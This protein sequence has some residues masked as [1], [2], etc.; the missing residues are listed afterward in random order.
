M[1]TAAKWASSEGG[2]QEGRKEH[3][4]CARLP[5]LNYKFRKMGFSLATQQFKR[6]EFYWV[7]LYT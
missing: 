3:I 4:N 2:Q 6:D 1:F 5:I 7:N